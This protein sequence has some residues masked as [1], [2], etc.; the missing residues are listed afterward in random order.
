[1]FKQNSKELVAEVSAILSTY[2]V[3]IGL[4]TAAALYTNMSMKHIMI[5]LMFTALIQVN[6]FILGNHLAKREAKKR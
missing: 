3:S 4:F 1:M 2:A 6:N 5:A